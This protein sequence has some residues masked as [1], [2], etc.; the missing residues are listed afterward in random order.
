MNRYEE[1]RLVEKIAARVVELLKE[2]DLTTNK[3]LTARQAAS[4]LG[5]TVK[6]VYNLTSLGVLPHT[7]IGRKLTFT[8]QSLQQYLHR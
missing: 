6:T 4:Y 8:E 1:N 3:V 2:N 5:V 7:K